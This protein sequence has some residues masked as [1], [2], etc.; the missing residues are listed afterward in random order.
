MKEVAITATAVRPTS[1]TKNDQPS[2]ITTSSPLT[3]STSTTTTTSSQISSAGLI[4]KDKLKE[5]YSMPIQLAAGELGI[6]TTMLKQICRRL[7]I[8]RWPHRKIQSLNSTICQLETTLTRNDLSEE[9]K[10]TRREELA[11]ASAKKAFIL[12]RPDAEVDLSCNK[13]E[14][15]PKELREF[16]LFYK[17]E[18]AFDLIVAPQNNISSFSIPSSPAP[19]STP[20]QLQNFLTRHQTRTKQG[21]NLPI[22]PTIPAAATTTNTSI[23][24]SFAP[25]MTSSPQS[26]TIV[27]PITPI[28]KQSVPSVSVPLINPPI[29]HQQQ[30]KTQ[31][32]I[33]NQQQYFYSIP[34]LLSSEIESSKKIKPPK[35]AK[36]NVPLC[37]IPIF[38]SRKDNEQGANQPSKQQII[39]MRDKS[40][41]DDSFS[42]IK[43]KIPKFDFSSVTP[44]PILTNSHRVESGESEGDED[45]MFRQQLQHHH[46]HHHHRQQQQQQQ[47][48]QKRHH[49]HSHSHSHHR[50]HHHSHSHSHNSDDDEV[51]ENKFKTESV[52]K[53]V[54]E[55]EKAY[56]TIAKLKEEC[57]YL[58]K[59]LGE[60][61]EERRS[62]D[63]DEMIEEEEEEEEFDTK[64]VP[65]VSLTESMKNNEKIAEDT[66]SDWL[67]INKGNSSNSTTQSPRSTTFSV[68]PPPALNAI[69]DQF[70]FAQPQ[71]SSSPSSSASSASSSF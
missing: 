42:P 35:E 24:S 18:P 52:E 36:I 26:S 46:S 47:E 41:S 70:M 12:E 49:H 10:Q 2:G 62:E 21:V 61:E 20:S 15:M 1:P 34:S 48:Q 30:H 53:Y 17:V 5:Y 54:F 7:G 68:S 43:A 8:Q 56:R 50:S 33:Q 3:L 16:I 27:P 63:S 6:C 14:K 57:S 45:F 31:V 66:L 9:M 23:T 37:P 51:E 32:Q 59:R 71:P 11:V 67:R 25:S 4:T 64:I 65:F 55:L 39:H 60:E 38:A 58:R 40:E 69:S 13:I 44:P 28:Q 19:P 29:A 22:I